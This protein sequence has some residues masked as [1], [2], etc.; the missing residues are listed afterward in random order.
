MQICGD[1]LTDSVVTVSIVSHGHGEDIRHLLTD[2]A[3]FGC[4]EIAEVVLTL[5]VPEEALV[6][7]IAQHDWPFAFTL[8][9]NDRSLGYGANH[10][11]A[12]E[13]C[14]TPYFCVLNPDIRFTRDPFPH[15][16]SALQPVGVGCTY[17]MQS[18][19]GGRPIDRVRE[20]PTPLALLRRYL[21]P[22][23]RYRPQSRHWVNGSF[24]LFPSDIF[25]QLGG[26]D[27]SYFMYCED[28]DICLRLQQT[29]LRLELA[30]Q[31]H[32]QHLA[33]RASRR[34]SRHFWW[35][36]RSLFRLWRSSTYR[37]C[38][39]PSRLNSDAK[40]VERL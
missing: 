13:H 40:P 11:Q 24:M 31:A 22:G 20:V 14:R 15:L 23:Y 38:C 4:K 6:D 2:M 27:T 17:P 33:T 5:N 10:N 35:H 1:I 19:E 9:R 36:I 37:Q 21:V 8:I 32:V 29:G 34:L 7:W 28:V 30:S 16:I 39:N 12:F 25:R 18:E 3:A 26:F